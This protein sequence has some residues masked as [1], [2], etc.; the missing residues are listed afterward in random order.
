ME[1]TPMGMLSGSIR[2]IPIYFI[3]FIILGLIATGYLDNQP[4]LILMFVIG[5]IALYII[6][7]RK[8]ES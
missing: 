5:L 1:K 3:G 6:L 7:P 8:R 2:E 4:L